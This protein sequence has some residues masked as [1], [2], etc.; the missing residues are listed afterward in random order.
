MD[1]G[2]GY[3]KVAVVVFLSAAMGLAASA[4]MAAYPQ[5]ILNREAV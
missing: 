4:T 2:L 3:L 1:Y 5:V